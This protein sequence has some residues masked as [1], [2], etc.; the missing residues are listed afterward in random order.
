MSIMGEPESYVR[1]RPPATQTRLVSLMIGMGSVREPG[2]ANGRIG[3]CNRTN[4][5]FAWNNRN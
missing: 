3:H 2:R 1:I 4:V 5:T